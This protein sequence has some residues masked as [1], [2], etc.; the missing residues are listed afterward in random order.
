MWQIQRAGVAISIHL[1]SKAAQEFLGPIVDGLH[2]TQ[3]SFSER[4]FNLLLMVGLAIG[5]LPT[6]K[7][8]SSVS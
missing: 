5:R 6:T 7:T 1:K 8:I 4:M 3:V 2:A